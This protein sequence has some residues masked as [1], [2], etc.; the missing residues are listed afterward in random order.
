MLSQ[1]ANNRAAEDFS[2]TLKQLEKG[3][4]DLKM[5]I[6]QEKRRHDMPLDA[7]LGDPEREQR[8]ADG[9]FD[10]PDNEEG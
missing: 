10:R 2:K 1:V 8:A 6:D 9:H 5:R 4:R 3:L 7:K